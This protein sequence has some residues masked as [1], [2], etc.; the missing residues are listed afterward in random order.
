MILRFALSAISGEH[1][2]TEL[3]LERAT[4]CGFHLATV[5]RFDFVP[6]ATAL[7]L[8]HSIHLDWAVTARIGQNINS[9]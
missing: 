8:Y 7:S 9:P 2:Q 6:S 1:R 3:L 4:V 5:A